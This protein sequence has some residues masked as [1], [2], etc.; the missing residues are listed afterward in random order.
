MKRPATRSRSKPGS[1]SKTSKREAVRRAKTSGLRQSRAAKW[2]LRL[3]VAGQ[4]P[5]SLAALA[6]LKRFCEENLVEGYEIEVVDLLKQPHLAKGD[7]IIA[8][9]TLV[10]KLP[11]PIR[12][13]IG[14]LSDR[15]RVMIGMDLKP[16]IG[17]PAS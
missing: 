5:R 13:I 9:P 16:R 6:N 17:G 2:N 3:Y 8:L 14:D 4:T 7:G 11:E 10:R 12:R 15:E 1:A